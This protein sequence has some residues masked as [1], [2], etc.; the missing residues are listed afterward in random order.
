[1]ELTYSRPF[2]E[3]NLTKCKMFIPFCITGRVPIFLHKSSVQCCPITKQGYTLD[4]VTMVGE[5]GEGEGVRVDSG[6]AT[7]A[8][9]DEGAAAASSV[10]DSRGTELARRPTSGDV[11]NKEPTSVLC[12]QSFQTISYHLVILE[13]PQCKIS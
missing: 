4:S 5:G 11:W 10:L 6:D 8:C 7:R 13:K 2:K 12:I 3:N 1:M 9:G